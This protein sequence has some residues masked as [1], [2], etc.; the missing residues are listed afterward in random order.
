MTAKTKIKF[1]ACL[2]AILLGF[3]AYL[4]WLSTH[5]PLHKGKSVK[6]WVDNAC[7][8]LDASD[9]WPFRQEVGEIGAPAVP[10]LLQNLRAKDW[11]HDKWNAFRTHLPQSW[12]KRFPEKLEAK[13]LHYGAARTIEF[14][15]P[16]AKAAVPDLICL[17]PEN[18]YQMIIALAA[19]GPDAHDALPTLHLMQ[20]NKDV[21][22]REEVA[23][24]LWQIGRETNLVLEISTNILVQSPGNTMNSCALLGQMGRAALPAAPFVLQVL[25]DTNSNARGNA[26]FVFG[27]L[28]LDTPE[29]RQAL[30]DCLES[31]Q[32]KGVRYNCVMALW[33]FDPS[34]APLGTRI[35]IEN[36]VQHQKE[37]PGMLDDFTFWLK[38]SQL[39]PAQSVPTLKELLTN[40]SPQIRS[41]AARTLAKIESDA[42]TS[43]KK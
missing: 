14:L 31:S 1:A 41:V 18:S 3:C 36:M 22:I 33:Q 17:L 29:I 28:H 19:I 16:S 43:A 37:A 2:T 23:R 38:R 42:K 21:H 5:E 30:H 24:A 35:V 34:Y 13:E 4:G 12:Q 25:R 8:G 9:R 40:D 10:Y 15:G 11:G 20:T 6:Y 27:N 26:A 39:D 7:I 32:D